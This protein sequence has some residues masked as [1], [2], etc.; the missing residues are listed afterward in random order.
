MIKVFCE[1]RTE[2]LGSLT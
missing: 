1:E 2:V